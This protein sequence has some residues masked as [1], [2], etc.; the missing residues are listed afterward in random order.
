[1]IIFA[2]FLLLLGVLAGVA[3]D[4]FSACR[5]PETSFGGPTST[6]YISCSVTHKDDQALQVQCGDRGTVIY[7]GDLNIIWVDL[8]NNTNEVRSFTI[9][10]RCMNGISS[11]SYGHATLH[12]EV[13]PH[14]SPKPIFPGLNYA[15]DLRRHDSLMIFSYC[16]GYRPSPEA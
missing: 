15:C 16:M 3:E 7:H 11:K 8:S 2:T 14:H 1:M 4:G 10:V 5:V 12:F 6:G 13:Q 9:H